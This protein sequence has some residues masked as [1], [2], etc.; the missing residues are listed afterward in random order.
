MRAAR[1][2]EERAGHTDPNGLS[3][4]DDQPGDVVAGRGAIQDKRAETRAFMAM[5]SDL[6]AVS[7]IN[8]HCV[9]EEFMEPVSADGRV[10]ADDNT[11]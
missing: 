6:R 9:R 10:E 1:L 4:G 5:L 8:C 3:T 2:P 11:L 7:V